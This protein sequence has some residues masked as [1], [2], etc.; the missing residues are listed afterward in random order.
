MKT[1]IIALALLLSLTGG[2]LVFAVGDQVRKYW[3]FGTYENI[4]DVIGR[5]AVTTGTYTNVKGGY[6]VKCTVDPQTGRPVGDGCGYNPSGKRDAMQFN[7]DSGGG[8]INRVGFFSDGRISIDSIA[9]SDGSSFGGQEL[10][11][12]VEGAIGAHHYCDEDGENCYTSAQLRGAIKLIADNSAWPGS[13]SNK[14]QVFNRDGRVL[15]IYDSA[16]HGGSGGWQP[17]YTKFM[18]YNA[19]Q[20]AALSPTPEVGDQITS[21]DCDLVLT[22]DGTNWIDLTNKKINTGTC[23]VIP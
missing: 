2:G 13:P 21:T 5:T 12:D 9:P 10:E 17:T 15:Q 20:I 18:G 8:M 4:D 7:Y 6:G 16:A 14:D 22:Y 23:A 3:G 11:F 1:R 19:S